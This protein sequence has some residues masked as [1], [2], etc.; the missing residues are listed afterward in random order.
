MGEKH[1]DNLD[2]S[3]FAISLAKRYGFLKREFA[4]VIEEHDRL[5]RGARLVVL[6]EEAALNK[7]DRLV[8][9]LLTGL[10]AVAALVAILISKPVG[11]ILFS[12]PFAP[13]CIAACA[14]HLRL[15]QIER[16]IAAN[17]KE[18]LCA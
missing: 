11:A 18:R 16:R 12:I 15:K 13:C 17:V 2:A 6:Q 4:E 7:H 10:L 9:A 3:I 14:A 5:R 8:Y 1:D